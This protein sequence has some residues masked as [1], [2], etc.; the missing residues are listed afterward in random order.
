LLLSAGLVSLP[1][2]FTI[3]SVP[4][5]GSVTGGTDFD[6]LTAGPV[7][8]PEKTDEDPIASLRN[9]IGTRPLEEEIER[10]A[11][12]GSTRRAV[13]VWLRDLRES[14]R[15]L[16]KEYILRTTG[17]D[18]QSH[19]YPRGNG[20]F[21]MVVTGIGQTNEELAA[22]ISKLGTLEKTYPEIQVIEVKV[23]NDSFIEG[24]IEKLNNRE[25]PAFYDL[26]KRELESIDLERVSKAVKRLAEAEPRVYRSDISRKLVGLLGAGWV[27][28]KADVCRA[29][30]VWAE[31][32]GEAGQTALAEA[33][34]LLEMEKPIPREM[35]ELI[36][37]EGTPG[38][39]PVID[40][41]WNKNPTSW[42]TMYAKAGPSAEPVLLSRLETSEGSL[43]HSVVRLLGHVGGPG[44][45]PA[46]EAALEGADPELE[47]LIGNA[48]AAIRTRSGG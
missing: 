14:N 21:L 24:A 29:L 30:M 13:G 10:L 1:F 26:N 38:L 20:D 3:G 27:D 2:F 16:V 32:P 17:A 44:S 22:I 41:L 19:Y 12:S 45:L 4:L 7:P 35:I 28:F 36:L 15:F 8:A 40:A 18:P 23:N 43:R 46:L 42:E 9:L 39:V 37:K 33:K 34:K 11:A 48:T 5:A 31:T 47:V 25:D 6:E